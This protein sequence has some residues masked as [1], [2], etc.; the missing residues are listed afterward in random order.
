MKVARRLALLGWLLAGCADQPGDGST[1]N[2]AKV[3]LK[4]PMPDG[5]QAQ[6]AGDGVLQVGPVGRPV[7]RIEHRPALAVP[8]AGDVPNELMADGVKVLGELPLADG[9]LIRY[10]VPGLEQAMIGARHL[11]TGA[12]LCASLPGASLDEVKQ[13]AALCTNV[14]AR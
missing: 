9:W 7:V 10:Q 3:G 4:I 2:A 12:L 11:S 5:W 13:A 6:P 8:D 1:G 14:G